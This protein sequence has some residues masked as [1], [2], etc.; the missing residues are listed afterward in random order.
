MVEE[1]KSLNFI[2]EIYLNNVY[3]EVPNISSFMMSIIAKNH[4]L[5]QSLIIHTNALIEK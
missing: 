3:L 4:Y 5:K 1:E 2:E